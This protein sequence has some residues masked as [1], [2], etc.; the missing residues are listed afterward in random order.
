MRATKRSREA[1]AAP[2]FLGWRAYVTGRRGSPPGAIALAE[3]RNE[4][5]VDTVSFRGPTTG[6]WTLVVTLTFPGDIGYATYWW[7]ANV[8]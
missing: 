8:P 6:D 3:G 2:S 1:W 4:T 5:G 7:D